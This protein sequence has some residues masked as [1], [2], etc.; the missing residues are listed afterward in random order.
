[1]VKRSKK[2]DNR[3]LKKMRAFSNKI[4]LLISEAYK[5]KKKSAKKMLIQIYV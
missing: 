5:Q 1:M 3:I 4:K 2:S